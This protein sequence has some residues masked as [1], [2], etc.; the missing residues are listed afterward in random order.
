MKR[1]S[2]CKIE[3]ENIFFGPQK[4]SKDGLT[5]WCKECKKNLE[6][7][8]RLS[9]G[10]KQKR[11]SKIIGETHKECMRCFKICHIDDF[12]ENSRGSLKKSAYCKPC[13][14]EYIIELKNS[15]K[16]FYNEKARKATQKYRDN[17]RLRWRALHR[18]NQFNRRFLIEVTD[19]G[20]VTDEFLEKLYST[21]Q[22]YWCKK[23]I[24]FENRTAEHVTALSLGGI[25]SE[26]NLVMACRSC[27]SSKINMRKN[28]HI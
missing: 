21:E 16:E 22:C 8:R 9:K 28:E 11:L 4:Q 2:K 20:T 12:N 3:K 24:Q 13:I 27:N 23:I 14:H 10:I 1:C 19:D 25:H 17:H 15:D 26:L 18:I 5:S 6:Q 7:Q